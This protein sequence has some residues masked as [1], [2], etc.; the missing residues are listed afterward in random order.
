MNGIELVD[1]ERSRQ[2]NKGFTAEHDDQ[3][4]D[5]SLIEASRQILNDFEVSPD[6]YDE[7]PSELRFNVRGKYGDDPIH[8]LV[9]AAA[10]I[11]AEIERLQRAGG[12]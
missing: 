5:G 6:D 3:H 2:C 8:R 10:L 9:I 4:T 11:V 1:Q 12:K 7:W